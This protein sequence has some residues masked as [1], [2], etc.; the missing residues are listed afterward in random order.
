MKTPIKEVYKYMLD[1]CKYYT[2][3]TT[4]NNYYN[5]LILNYGCCSG[6]SRLV[7]LMNINELEVCIILATIKNKDI[8]QVQEQKGFIYL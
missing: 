3:T 2:V 4:K 5:V 7:Y 6:S 8:Q 1:N